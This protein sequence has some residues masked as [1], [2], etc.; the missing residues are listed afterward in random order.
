MFSV[1]VGERIR[2]RRQEL[3]LKQKELAELL[4]VTPQAISKWE[5]GESSPDISH[6]PRLASILNTT[7]D[8]LLGSE[9]QEYMRSVYLFSDF[10]DNEI[11]LFLPNFEKILIRSGDYIYNCGSKPDDGFYIIESGTVEITHERHPSF[12]LTKGKSFSDCSSLDSG[13][14]ITNACAVED[15]VI[16]KVTNSAICAFVKAYPSTGAKL[17]FNSLKCTVKYLRALCS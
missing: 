12:R 13:A 14:C 7:S 4:Y 1:M 11:R 6:L 9:L 17:Y 2:M 8:W 5:R 15:T 16:F 3:S 10:T